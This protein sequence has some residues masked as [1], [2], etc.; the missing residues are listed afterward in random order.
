MFLHLPCTLRTIYRDFKLLFFKII[1]TSMFGSLGSMSIELFMILLLKWIFFLSCFYSWYVE[2]IQRCVCVCMCVC[3]CVA[4]LCP[5]LCDPMGCSPPGFSICGVLQLNP[6]VG[7]HSLLQ[8]IFPTR[9]SNL[10]L[11]H[12]RQI[13]YCRSQQESLHAEV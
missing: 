12:C 2:S 13:L 9:E 1:F 11:P 8:G 7:C 5:A 3:V 6:G 4:E 10:G